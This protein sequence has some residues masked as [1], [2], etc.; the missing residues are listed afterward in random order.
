MLI[1]YYTAY[2][3]WSVPWNAL[4]FEMT[5]DYNERT[6]VQAWRAVFAT[7]AG[8]FISWTYKLCFLFNENEVIGARYVGALIGLIL[9]VTGMASAFFCKERIESQQQEKIKLIPA[10]TTTLKN[11]PFLL[12]CGSVALF[13]VGVFLVQPMAIYVNIY[14]VFQGSENARNAASTISG[15]GGMCGAILGLLMIPIISWLGTHWGKKQTLLLGMTGAAISFL[16][17]IVT[18]NPTHPYMELISFCMMS[19]CIAFIWLILPSMVADVCDVDELATGLRREGMYGAVYG[20]ILKLGVSIGLLLSGFVL[21]LAGIVPAAEI[22]SPEAIRNLRILFSL[23]P[24]IFTMG[25]V[26][27]M[28]R[29]P[30]TEAA[31]EKLKHEID[32]LRKYKKANATQ[33]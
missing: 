14:Y 21:T 25:A 23:V 20:W 17:Q 16:I 8:L 22:Q 3:I 28:V 29:Y 30:L 12:V 5:P 15:L 7:S 24:F 31:M 27:L 6:R 11:R 9:L 26:I 10:F 19:P 13:I 4:G 1:G 18:F 2:T 33:G 32:A